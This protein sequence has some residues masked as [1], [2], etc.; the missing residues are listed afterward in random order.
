L[1]VRADK[2]RDVLRRSLEEAGHQVDEVAAYASRPLDALDD[3]S[4]A[5]VAA[6]VDWVTVTSTSIAEATARL[7]ADR[8]RGW[9]IASISPVTTAAL[10]RAGLDVTVEADEA[11]AAGLVAAM[12]RW[13]SAAAARPAESS[14]SG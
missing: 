1:L 6:G 10:R 13:E 2:G 7:F 14:R 5:A 11:S 12:S 8:I 9:R 4:Q 3:E